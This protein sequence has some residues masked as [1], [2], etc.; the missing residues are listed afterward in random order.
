M[1]I[2]YLGHSSFLLRGKTAKVITD[3]YDSK[4]VGITFPKQEA[5]IVT[6]SHQHKDHNDTSRIEGE[7]LIIYLPGEYEKKTVRV[8]GYDSDHDNQK[9]KKRGNNTIYKIEIDD[10]SVLHLGDLGHI[11]SDDLVEEIDAV[12]V[13]LIPV[14]GFYTIGPDQAVKTISQIEPSF[15]IPMHYKSTKVKGEGFEKLATL[16]EFLKQADSLGVESIKKLSLKKSDITDDTKI[17][18]MEIG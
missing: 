14:G 2:K 6:I 16:E 13:L 9:G 11:L 1:D 5:D 10:I 17:I 8:T 4:M 3:P 15:V 12:D 18:V 7:P